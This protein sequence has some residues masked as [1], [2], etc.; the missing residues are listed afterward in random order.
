MRAEPHMFDEQEPGGM[1]YDIE[2]TDISD[3]IRYAVDTEEDDLPKLDCG[4]EKRP[5]IFMPR[6]ASRI[7]L[8]IKDIRVERVQDISPSDACEEGIF[9]GSGHDCVVEPP[10]PYPVAT[11]K[12]LWNSINAKRGYGWDVN[13]WVWVIKFEVSK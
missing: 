11:F 6:W 13:P 12:V 8:L 7:T 9:T 3:Y 1:I 2:D 10:L 5:S 4:W